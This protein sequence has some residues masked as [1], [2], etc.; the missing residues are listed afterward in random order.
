MTNEHNP[1]YYATVDNDDTSIAQ[2]TD[3]VDFPHTG[4]IKALSLGIKGNYAVK[5]S[6]TDFD[7]TQTAHD[8]SGSGGN[9]VVVAEGKI[10][11]DGA[12]HTVG[13]AN[14]TAT[15]FQATQNTHHLLVATGASTP[16]LAI[17]KHGSST[18]NAIPPY[19]DGDTIIAVL[20]YTGSNSTNGFNAMNVQFLTTNKVANNVSV[21][22]STGTAP[23]DI[24]NEAMSIEGSATRTLFKNKVADAD[25]RFVLADNT[26]DERFEIY[27]DD[28]SD[29]DEGDTALFTVDGLGATTITGATTLSSIAACG[30]DTDKFL[31]S[32][33]GVIK[34][35]TGTEVASDIGA[36]TGTL[37]I[38]NNN[39]LQANANL[40]D[41]D[42]LRVDGTQIEG[43]TAAETLSDIAAMPLAG[44]TFTG[45]VTVN[46]GQTFRTPRLPTVSVSART[47]LTEAT[48]AGAYLICAGN[49]TLPATS[50]AGEHYTILNTTGGNITVGR[51][52]NNINGAGSD[53]TVAT[54]NGVTCIAIGSNNWIALGV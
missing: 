54:F 8:G 5:G 29:G 39:I 32:D 19:D 50:S 7:I 41:D 38:A 25:I 4:L 27:S 13:T 3:A 24:Y 40:A 26:A 49:V 34:F 20:T 48:H 47:T 53:A 17:R 12:L 33:S 1:H 31:V 46:T 44:G 22:Y 42:F 51:N 36:L 21:G 43:R 10:F 23:S 45:A 2:I 6:T 15:S 11:R 52:G 16:V 28:D 30:S 9:V 18:Q 35:R 14:F 37:G